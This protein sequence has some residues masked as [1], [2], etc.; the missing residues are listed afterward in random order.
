M[1]FYDDASLVVI[2]SGYKTSKVY[3]EKPTDGSGDLAFTRTGDTATR[4]NSAGLIEKVRTNLILQSQTFDNASWLKSLVGGASAPVVTANN[5]T[6]PDGTLTAD[7][8]VFVAPTSGD[9]S[10]LT[11]NITVTGIANGSVYLKA[12]AAGDV[13]K[14]LAIRFNSGSYALA[15]LTADWQRFSVSQTAIVGTFDIALRPAIGSSSGTVS[16]FVW[17]AQLEAGD[18]AT[19]YIPTTTAA[20]SVGPVANVPRLDYLGS[21]C[22]R[23]LLEGQRSNLMLQSENL[24][25]SWSQIR[26]TA[27]INAA[28][29]P[30]GYANA[31]KLIANTD[32]STTHFVIQTIT[33][34]AAGTYAYSTFF[35]K[36]EYNFGCVRIS[37]NTDVQR[38]TA[39]V[40]LTTGE[41]TATS[42]FGSPTATSTKV[43]NYGN[44]WYRLSVTCG[45]TLGNILCVSTL[46]PTAV[47]TFTNNIPAFTGDGTSGVFTW[48]AQLELG[49]YA[50]SY[51][52]T[53]SAS[54][55]RGADAASKTGI[56]SLIGQTEGVLFVDFTV[57]TI[58]AQTND[59]V[60]CY[61]KDGGV[62]ERYVQLYSTGNLRYLEN[63]GATIATITKTG[64]S[65]G[66]HKCAIAYANNDMVFY[67]DG[68][69]IGTD[70]SGT[71]SG[72]STFALQYYNAAYLGQ[73][74]VNQALL[75]KTRLTNA[76]LA[77]LTTL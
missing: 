12:F 18:I 39:V 19:D 3:A 65:V 11:Q 6:A 74:K 26:S 35:K 49:A 25:A 68:V 22:P 13:G 59:P 46:S 57:D 45:H 42:S 27:T 47:P 14:I 17:G 73:Q 7:K 44:G 1:S 53:L 5:T 70:T 61:M 29:S 16:I 51:I 9:I 2:P 31:D 50:T 55:T 8:I 52:P 58:S 48:G 40:N 24:S 63:N 69:Q 72:F 60:L 10:Q 43:D 15:T 76:Q 34:P 41:V 36:S 4:V 54:A 21:T 20:V 28:V 23:L 64:L 37:T 32:A 67:V 33:S 30:D 66:R 77:E 56:S 62:G 71:P 75:F 38:F